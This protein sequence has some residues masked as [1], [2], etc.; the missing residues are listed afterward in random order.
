MTLPVKNSRRVIDG[1]GWANP[2]THDF[3][4][5]SA[6]YLSVFADDVQ[7]VLGVDY[8][9]A[10]LNNPA[11]Y[12]V[13]I[14]S[15]VDWNPVAWVLSVEYP[16]AQPSDVDQGG[17]FGL[18]FEAALDRMALGMQTMDDRT[19]RALKV[20][21][22]TD[23]SVSVEVDAPQPDSVLGWNADGTRVENKGS[24]PQIQS[25]AEHLAEIDNLSAN[26]S[27]LVVV[28]A[29]LPSIATV[30]GINA[31]VAAVAAVAPLLPGIIAMDEEIVAVAANAANINTVALDIDNVNDVASN[32]ANIN[33]VAGNEVNINAAVANA[34]N[35]NNVVANSGNINAVAANEVNINAVNANKAHIDSVANNMADVVEVAGNMA[36]LNNLNNNTPAILQAA[37][38]A[39]ASATLAQKWAANPEDVPVTSGLFSAFHWAQKAAAIVAGS[40]VSLVHG[41]AAKA[42]PVDADEL[43]LVD[44]ADGWSLKKLT[45]A[46]LKARLAEQM[47]GVAAG[48]FAA[49]DDSR[50][51]GA[52]L[53]TRK[54]D[55]QH[56]LQGGG[57][58]SADRT[59]SLAGDVA[60][61]GNNKVYGTDGA[62]AR[63]WQDA[64][65]GVGVG[66]TWQAV[67]RTKGTAYQNTTGKPIMLA[68]S[69]I[70]SGTTIT[71]LVSVGPTSAVAA[72]NVQQSTPAVNGAMGTVSLVIPPDWYYKANSTGSID[73]MELR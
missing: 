23:P 52:V 58:L 73:C 48:T 33:A 12:S 41:A 24:V 49:G 30:A 69:A 9:I 46:A 51:V 56:S 28:E 54:V 29:A 57:N 8:T 39:S 47:T 26:M 7:L 15:P 65:T 31:Q 53:S 35:I 45:W 66:Q 61:P 64:P 38:D 5:E 21:N 40:W 42:S 62:G 55:T 22:T 10:G 59:L 71:M 63:G 37:D 18:R 20:S 25:V 32:T 27:T 50:I 67:S 68:Y 19:K 1:T 44:S 60:A 34:N 16:I 13:T 14:S 36:A 17:Q 6:S 70:S 72:G 11:G 3:P 43:G 4:L 2:L